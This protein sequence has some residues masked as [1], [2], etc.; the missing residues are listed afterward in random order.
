MRG[1]FC[2]KRVMKDA[3]RDGWT[4]L[5][6][7]S[8]QPPLSCWTDG[9]P[10]DQRPEQWQYPH[11]V[12]VHPDTAALVL[13]CASESGDVHINVEAFEALKKLA[14]EV[15]TYAVVRCVGNSHEPVLS[16]DRTLSSESVQKRLAHAY[17]R[18]G[19]LGRYVTISG[20]TLEVET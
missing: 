11:D 3:H 20:R 7:G 19:K 10:V 18:D 1:R 12:L 15:K 5:R 6:A 17:E 2:Y 8:T 9:V 14:V 13:L 4:L 16:W